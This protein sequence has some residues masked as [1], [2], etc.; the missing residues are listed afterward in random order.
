[1]PVASTLMLPLASTAGLELREIVTNGTV[2][3]TLT[4]LVGS[5]TEVAVT[6]T[7]KLLA[8]AVEGAL[9]V[10]LK[11]SWVRLFASEVGETVNVTP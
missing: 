9:Y 3:V 10:A 7:I 1:M 6:V 11:L 5:S 4:D 8:G 2:M